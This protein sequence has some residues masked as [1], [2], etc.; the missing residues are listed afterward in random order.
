MRSP[1]TSA[2][3]RQGGH[4]ASHRIGNAPA[5]LLILPDSRIAAGSLFQSSRRSQS[6]NL[7]ER[8]ELYSANRIPERTARQIFVS[9]RAE[10]PAK[11]HD[12]SAKRRVKKSTRR[13]VS[14]VGII[15]RA[16]SGRPLSCDLPA[17][18]GHLEG[19]GAIRTALTQRDESTSA[20]SHGADSTVLIHRIT[21]DRRAGEYRLHIKKVLGFKHW[22]TR[23][24]K[25]KR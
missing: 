22:D 8:G 2:S 18:G 11:K 3:H 19:I 13:L 5:T 1:T 24:Q 21:K 7:A 20:R 12:G 10:N 16:I 14:V 25:P 15:G 4:K 17:P 9:S 23:R 6:R